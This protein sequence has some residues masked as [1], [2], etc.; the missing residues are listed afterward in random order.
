[1]N[2]IVGADQQIV[3]AARITEPPQ[4]DG[5]GVC[6]T[7]SIDKGKVLTERGKAGHEDVVAVLRDIE[8]FVRER[9]DN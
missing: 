6:M 8:L 5:D 1:M 9:V 4:A 2:A 7:R 3:G